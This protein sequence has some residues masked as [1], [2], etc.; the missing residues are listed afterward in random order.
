MVF[1][2]DFHRRRHKARVPRTREQNRAYFELARHETEDTHAAEALFPQR[3]NGRPFGSIQPAAIIN[4]SGPEAE[5]NP[6]LP[7]G[8]GDMSDY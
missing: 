6:R 5:I 2:T 3:H 7:V 8:S 4:D 1:D